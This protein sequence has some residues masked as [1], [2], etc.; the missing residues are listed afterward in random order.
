MVGDARTGQHIRS[1]DAARAT[2]VAAVLEEFEDQIRE[3]EERHA[4][5]LRSMIRRN[6]N[7]LNQP[8]AVRSYVSLLF[9]GRS[10]QEM[11]AIFGKLASSG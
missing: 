1:Q 9:E 10:I 4:T 2:R 8:G 11:L 6:D 7:P 5:H 3:A